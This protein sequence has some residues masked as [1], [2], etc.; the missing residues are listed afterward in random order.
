MSFTGRPSDWCSRTCQNSLRGRRN[1]GDNGG[2][3]LVSVCLSTDPTNALARLY[4]DIFA[5]APRLADAFQPDVGETSPAAP[6]AARI[7]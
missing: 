4:A 5:D 2:R 7:K 3:A 1:P 6:W